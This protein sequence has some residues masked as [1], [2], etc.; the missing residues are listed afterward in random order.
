MYF[1][2]DKEGY[3]S[4]KLILRKKV[5]VA[6]LYTNVPDIALQLLREAMQKFHDMNKKYGTPFKKLIVYYPKKGGVRTNGR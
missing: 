4:I 3:F 2:Q 1:E 6:N 5:T